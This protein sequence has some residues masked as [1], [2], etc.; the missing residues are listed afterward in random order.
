[1]ASTA[2]R[3][4]FDLDSLTQRLG[5]LVRELPVEQMERFDEVVI[6]GFPDYWWGERTAEQLNTQLTIKRDYEEWFEVFRS[7]FSKATDDLD[8]RIQEADLEFRKWVELGHNYSLRPDPSSNEKEL[9][10]DAQP[11]FDL[12][13]VIETGGPMESV[14]VPDTNAII[15]NPDPTQYRAINGDHSFTFLLLPTVIAELDVLKN[16]HRNPDFREKVHKTITRV[17]GW[18]YQGSLLDGVTVDKT[19]TVRAV[20]TEPDMLNTLSWLDKDNKDDRIIASALDVQSSYP[21]ARVVLVTGDIN[22]LNKA[23]LA[24]IETADAGL[25]G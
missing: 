15:S 7:V 22:L 17:K 3:L 18:R 13:T 25:S 11:F 9:Q 21:N 2:E 14:L 16:T 4:R 8:R 12:L 1:M 5:V 20:A 23:D 6:V 10:D 24:R 19:I